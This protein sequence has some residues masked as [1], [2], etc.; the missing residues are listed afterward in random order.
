MPK[1]IGRI[2][3]QDLEAEKSIIGAILLDRDAIVS[4]VQVLKPE[5]F[6]RQAHADIYSAILALFERR[7]PIDL[8]TLTAQLKSKGRFDEVG[9]AAYLAELA[10][11]VPTSAHIAQY[12][13]I[14]RDHYVKRQLIA[15]SA[16]V[17]ERAFDE[18]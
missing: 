6:Y 4:T 1:S 2:P 11:A 10:A 15:T 14:V 5:H 7:E 18:R 3:P 8:V 13:Q 16:K 12:A 17:T 9:G